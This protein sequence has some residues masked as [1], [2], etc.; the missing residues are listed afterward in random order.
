MHAYDDPHLSRDWAS[1]SESTSPIINQRT[2]IL[3]EIYAQ[4]H[5]IAKNGLVGD[6]SNAQRTSLEFIE[7]PLALT[8]TEPMPFWH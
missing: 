3:S 5:P 6:N 2:S 1:S 8:A 4:D 7:P